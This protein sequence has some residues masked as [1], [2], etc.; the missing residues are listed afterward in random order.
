MRFVKTTLFL[1]F[2]FLLAIASYYIY[3]FKERIQWKF[4]RTT[5]ILYLK[6][7]WPLVFVAVSI[8]LYSKIDQVM[9]KHF[10]DA[11]SVGYY[12]AALKI[13]AIVGFIPSVIVSSIYPKIIEAKEKGEEV[14]LS[15]LE[16]TYR[17]VFW[18]NILFIITI[19]FFSYDIISL[20]YGKQ[21]IKSGTIL[22]L[23]SF[24]MI[25]SAVDTVFTK[26]LYIEHYERKYLHKSIVGMFVNIMLNYFLIPIYGVNG[27]VFATIITLFIINY[28]YDLFDKDLRKLYHLKLKCFI[29]KI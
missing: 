24:G 7:I 3:K 6:N 5:A 27:A 13:I 8:H 20:L 11:S 29:P 10:I 2:S 14:Y 26:M 22:I 17:L 21:Y 18:I 4:D 16:K 1:I 12:A 25:F 28:I 15:I 19:F 9:L 23:L